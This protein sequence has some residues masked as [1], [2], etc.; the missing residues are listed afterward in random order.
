MARLADITVHVHYITDKAY[1]VSLDGDDDN[2]VWLP[3]SIVDCASDPA[4]GKTCEM[5]LPESFAQEK[6]LI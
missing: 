2:A 5:T 3:A 1:R 4:V 6:G